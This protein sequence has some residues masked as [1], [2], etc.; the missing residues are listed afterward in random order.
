MAA[1]IE[2]TMIAMTFGR[3]KNS[4]IIS[5]PFPDF[6]LPD[7]MSGK[8]VQDATSGGRLATRF[9]MIMCYHHSPTRKHPVPTGD[10]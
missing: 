9:F 2:I 8:Q 1:R 7:D 6:F 10:K 5:T 4:L 3:L